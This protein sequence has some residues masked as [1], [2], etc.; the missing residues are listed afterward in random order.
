MTPDTAV[1]M[2]TYNSWMNRPLYDA[3]L[4]MHEPE[5]ITDRGAFFG[6]LLQTLNHI[7]VGDTIWLHR[8]AQC[9]ASETL[10]SQLLAFPAPTSLH[11]EVA[12]SLQALK[13]YRS[14]LDELILL[15]ARSLTALQ[16]AAPLQYKNMAGVIQSKKFG[17]LVQHFFNQK[18]LR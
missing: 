13:V 12:P 5:V 11:Q 2:A 17:S 15:W 4:R 8:F 9:P 6:S 16:L 14:T 7:A 10:R 3:A 1:L 18:W